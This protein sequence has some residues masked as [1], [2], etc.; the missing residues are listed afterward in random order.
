MKS[1]ENIYNDY[2][3][4]ITDLPPKDIFFDFVQAY[5][6]YSNSVHLLDNNVEIT[7]V[8]A[9]LLRHICQNKGLTLTDIV[10]YWGR[11]KGTVSS[12]ISKLEQ[13]G[14]VYRQKCDKNSRINHIF[15]TEKGVETYERYIRFN[16]AE[17]DE[18]MEK[19]LEKYT[20][21]D[22]DFLLEMMQF[23]IDTAN[24]EK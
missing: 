14:F 2:S 1:I 20:F 12:Q 9:H 19:W 10:N 16:K 15:P 3:H 21:E 13:K 23:Y 11:T 5:Q 6:R 4:N 17:V 8:E 22:A 24:I 18:F 7:T